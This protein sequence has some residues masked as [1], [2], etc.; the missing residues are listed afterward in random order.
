MVELA[1]E[2]VTIA[3]T[4]VLEAEG[5]MQHGASN[6]NMRNAMS[7]EVEVKDAAGRGWDFVALKAEEASPLLK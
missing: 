6:P 5:L 7:F 4:L 1:G 3:F 2:P